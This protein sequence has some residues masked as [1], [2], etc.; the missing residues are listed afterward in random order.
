M[1]NKTRP[2]DL[3]FKPDTL[4]YLNLS[5]WLVKA[6]KVKLR[7]SNINSPANLK[8]FKDLRVTSIRYGS[9]K[10][11]FDLVFEEPVPDD[12][13]AD[14]E[15]TLGSNSAITNFA[16]ALDSG[17][18]ANMAI[19]GVTKTV[20]VEPK[21]N[22]NE[23]SCDS[24]MAC[25]PKTWQCDKI[26]DCPL[27]EDEVGCELSTYESRISGND[28]ER[29]LVDETSVRVYQNNFQPCNETLFI[30]ADRTLGISHPGFPSIYENDVNC[31]FEINAPEQFFMI[32]YLKQFTLES[33]DTKFF[34][35]DSFRI[36]DRFQDAVYANGTNVAESVFSFD[37]K[38]C[39]QVNQKESL[40]DPINHP[41]PPRKTVFIY[42]STQLR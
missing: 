42:D 15:S 21:C 1:E 32:I 30:R 14:L 18:L 33:Q 29:L 4:E 40:F 39:G 8:Y 7:D 9:I 38:F 2:D 16:A 10:C 12:K 19:S 20:A 34:C 35:P 24:A 37:Q 23:F 26:V 13:D 27:A 11:S 17:T 41:V 6:F 22:D 5:E 36:Q 28:T 3:I 31:E 25:I